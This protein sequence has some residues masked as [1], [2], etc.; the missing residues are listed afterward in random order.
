[1]RF[2]KKKPERKI[3][4]WYQPSETEFLHENNEWVLQWTENSI[5]KYYLE[6]LILHEL[7]HLVDSYFKRYWSKTYKKNKAENYADNFA[8]FWG[9]KLRKS[10]S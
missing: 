2:G 5:K 9:S 6:G 3:L 10:Y 7:G 8:I 4:N 1:M